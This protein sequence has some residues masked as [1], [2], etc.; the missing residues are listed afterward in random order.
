MQ[1]AGTSLPQGAR[2][3]FFQATLIRDW[4]WIPSVDGLGWTLE[5][6]VKLYLVFFILHKFHIFD[7][8]LRLSA[9]AGVGTFVNIA[10]KNY[11]ELFLNQN[12]HLYT[13]LYIITTTIIFIIVAMFGAVFYQASQNNWPLRECIGAGL[14]LVLCFYLALFSTTYGTTTVARSYFTGIGIFL[15]VFLLRDSLAN[16]KSVFLSAIRFLS[17][18]SF[19]VYVIHGLNG[20]YL[21]SFLDAMG[22]NPYISLLLTFCATLIVSYILYLCVERPTARLVASL[23]KSCSR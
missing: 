14:V 19:S 11:M 3:F 10:L 20:Y 23:G 9:L 15:I 7:N 1:W 5:V 12:F 8:P 2:D 16:C 13:T 21:L 6:Q 18:I 4:L 22:V 17:K